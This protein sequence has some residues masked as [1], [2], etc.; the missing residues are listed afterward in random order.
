MVCGIRGEILSLTN[1]EGK[2]RG[3][4]V[5]LRSSEDH[6]EEFVGE[7]DGGEGEL[8]ARNLIV[9]NLELGMSILYFPKVGD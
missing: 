5:V 1:G 2:V 4:M 8:R 6:D 3:K 7:E 9:T